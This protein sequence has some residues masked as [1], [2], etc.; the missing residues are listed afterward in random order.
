MSVSA[1]RGTSRG[2]SL[3]GWGGVRLA[4][5]EGVTGT[6]ILL[7]AD[8]LLH[9]DSS[10]HSGPTGLGAVRWWPRW[11]KSSRVSLEVSLEVSPGRLKR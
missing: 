6:P 11:V 7:S 2:L 5:L 3:L 4:I 10:S 8:L 1:C 9:Q